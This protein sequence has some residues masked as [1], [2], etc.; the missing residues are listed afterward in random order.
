M[1]L[2]DC[3]Q[4]LPRGVSKPGGSAESAGIIPLNPGSTYALKITALGSNTKL[5]ALAEI[6]CA[7][8]GGNI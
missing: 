5:T 4:E 7:C 2:I 6:G 1:P 3:Y 8:E